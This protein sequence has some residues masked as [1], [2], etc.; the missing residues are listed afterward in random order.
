MLLFRILFY[1]L[2]LFLFNSSL[3]AYSQII[4]SEIMYD[5]KGEDN[6]EWIELVNLGSPIEFYGNKEGWRLSVN[7]KNYLFKTDNFLWNTNE[8]ILITKNKDLFISKYPNITNKII[9]S[10]FTLPNKNGIIKILDKNKNVLVSLEYLSS[11][12]GKGNG[13]TLIFDD[14]ELK[15]GNFPNG[16]PGIY[17]EPKNI[18]LNNNTITNNLN[19]NEIKNNE[20]KNTKTEEPIKENNDQDNLNSEKFISSLL[21]DIKNNQAKRSTTSNFENLKES[22]NQQDNNQTKYLI[23]NEF[24]PNNKGKDVYEFV[25]I[26][27]LGDKEIDLTDKKNYLKIGNK[28]I[29]LSGKINPKDFLIIRNSDYGF[30]IR[31]N[32]EELA[33]IEDGKEIF[34]IKY[35]GK[36]PEDLSFSRKN[37]GKWYWT[38]PTPG[39][40]NIFLDKNQ[41]QNKLI[42]NKDNFD[43]E[44]FSNVSIEQDINLKKNQNQDN[45]FLYGNIFKTDDKFTIFT[46][47]VIALI[48]SYL[49]SKTVTKKE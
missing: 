43:Q 26:L 29:K 12:G 38:I 44:Y 42:K 11:L 4:I 49:I 35:Q 16:T 30:N 5:D 39:K 13:Y 47:F 7:N 31:N 28:K 1:L 48:I 45:K 36:A 33:L 37:N 40:E 8:V 6:N 18:N 21:E 23:I 34:Y 14:N 9:Q 10:S 3:Y 17:P 20:I 32:S 41:Y 24:L 15:Q 25:E 19:T 2:L 46:V 22:E 27:N